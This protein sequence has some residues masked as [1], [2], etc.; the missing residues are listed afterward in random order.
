MAGDAVIMTE[1]R[2]QRETR[3]QIARATVIKLALV[4]GVVVVS[5]VFMWHNYTVVEQLRAEAKEKVETYVRL[6]VRAVDQN[7]PSPETQLIF[8]EV[9]SRADFPIIVTSAD[10]E[11]MFWRNIPDIPDNSPQLDDRTRIAEILSAMR[12]ENGEI[13]IRFGSQNDS[14]LTA[15][16][17]N[18]F[19]YGDSRLIENLKRAPYIQIAIVVAFLLVGFIGMSNIK[20]SDERHIWVGMAKET[21][22]QLGTPITSLMGWLELLRSREEQPSSESSQARLPMHEIVDSMG[23]DVRR[24]QQVANRFGMIGSAPERVEADF[25]ALVADTARYY[26]KRV[27]FGG[28]GVTIDFEAGD[29]P[30]VLI[31]PELMGWAVENLV[32]NAMQ[33]VDS[34]AGKIRLSTSIASDRRWVRLEVHDNGVG[35]PVV[36]QRLVFRP[37]YTSKKRG[38]GLGLTLAKRIIQEYHRGKIWLAHSAPND[39]LFVIH[40]PVGVSRR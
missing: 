3:I 13:E 28:A 25:N 27:P 33:A 17:V 2:A 19:Y 39:T 15:V 10:R 24:L 1:T 11:P 29:V 12:A 6:W 23:V 26:R 14:T 20:K 4:A 31:N 37:G 18:Y 34:R 30:P 36:K 38:W 5:I 40:L 7:T 35:I 21:A 22:H 32:S 8:D 9:I 16:G